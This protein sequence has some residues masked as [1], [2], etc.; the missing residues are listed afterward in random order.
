MPFAGRLRRALHAAMGELGDKIILTT[1]LAPVGAAEIR[2]ARAL[3]VPTMH[4]SSDDPWNPNFKAPWHLRALREYDKVFTPRRS[5]LA[6]LQ[7]LGCR[8]VRYLPFGYDSELFSA[9][10]ESGTSG[11]DSRALFVGGADL[12]RA[13]FIRAFRRAGGQ[14]ALVGGYWGRFPDL[15]PDWLGRLAPDRVAELTRS[16]MVNL[17][18]V[19]EANRDGHTMRSFE[20]GAIGGCLLVQ[21]TLEHRDIFGPDGATVRYFD[22]PEQAARLARTL[23]QQPGERTRLAQAVRQRIRGG[24]HT[25]RDR[26]ATML[27]AASDQSQ[28]SLPGE[29]CHA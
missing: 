21:D 5:N 16:A 7:A 6:D 4:F 26:L 9:S 25:Y 20:A 29:I 15:K 8:D 19:R 2:M 14:T 17:I 13:R 23:M 27:T 22:G 1:G 10:E 3:G 24:N 18:L 28:G 12:D 11:E